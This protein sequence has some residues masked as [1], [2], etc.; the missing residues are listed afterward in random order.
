MEIYEKATA[1]QYGSLI[2]DCSGKSK[3]FFAGYGNELFISPNN[4]GS[5]NDKR[6]IP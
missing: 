5:N 6:D 2:I 3:R 4:I 1:E